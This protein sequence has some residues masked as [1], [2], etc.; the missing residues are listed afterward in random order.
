MSEIRQHGN[1]RYLGRAG[2]T[3]QGGYYCALRS[4]TW[5]ERPGEPHGENYIFDHPNYYSRYM[6]KVEKGWV[7]ARVCREG[8]GTRVCVWWQHEQAHQHNP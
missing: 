3:F 5:W 4:V 8:V 1:E 7:R 6:N 2:L